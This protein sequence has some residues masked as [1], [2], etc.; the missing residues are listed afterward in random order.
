M[1][2]YICFHSHGIYYIIYWYFHLCSLWYVV[3]LVYPDFV[4]SVPTSFLVHVFLVL[5]VLL[6]G[7][8]WHADCSVCVPDLFLTGKLILNFNLDLCAL[9][10]GVDSWCH[11]ITK[12]HNTVLPDWKT[13]ELKMKAVGLVHNVCGADILHDFENIVNLKKL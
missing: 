5:W 10:R 8:C 3:L 7:I 4:S 6:I 2:H 12:E 1:T 9:R 11:I 13:L